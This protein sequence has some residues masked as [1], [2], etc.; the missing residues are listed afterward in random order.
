MSVNVKLT[1]AARKKAEYPKLRVGQ[2]GIVVLFV[3]KTTGTV[4]RET[5]EYTLGTYLTDWAENHFTD[6]NGSVELSNNLEYQE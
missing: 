2:S 1:K 6:F 3:D 5:M 4:V